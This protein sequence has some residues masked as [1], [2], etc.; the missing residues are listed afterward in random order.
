M[1]MLLFQR[2]MEKTIRERWIFPNLDDNVSWKYQISVKKFV[3]E[4]YDDWHGK[5]YVK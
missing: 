5:E 1:H 4:M 3:V 2:W